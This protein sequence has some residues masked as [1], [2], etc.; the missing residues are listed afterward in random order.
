MTPKKLSTATVL[1]YSP[2]A[3]TTTTPEAALGYLVKKKQGSDFIMNDVLRQTTGVAEIEK[4]TEQQKIE[5]L[6]L[7]KVALIQED[8]FAQG[9]ALGEVAGHKEALEKATAEINA[10]LEKLQNMV[11]KMSE[12]KSDLIHQNEAH[13]I[14][15]IYQIA[16]KLAFDHIESKPEIIISVIKN[17]I[18]T[19]QADENV[20]VSVAPEQIHFIEQMKLKTGREFEFLKTIK[21]QAVDGIESAGCVVETNYGVIDARI[22]ERTSQLWSEIKQA[23]PKVK[24]KVG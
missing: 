4:Q 13:I 9:F 7:E 6:T 5:S 17:A 23:L 20:V 1:E 21:L 22:P 24:L 18:E 15:M 3:F 12:I 8:A 2:K 19:A 16:E 10:G 11:K 14:T